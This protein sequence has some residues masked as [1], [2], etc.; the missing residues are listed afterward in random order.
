MD[1]V[2]AHLLL[3]RG[4]PSGEDDLRDGPK[5]PLATL[6]AGRKKIIGS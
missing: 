3:P 6:S 2:V 1:E 5:D 4:E